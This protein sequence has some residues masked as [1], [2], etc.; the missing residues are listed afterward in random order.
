MADST[1][2]DSIVVD[3]NAVEDKR[4]LSQPLPVLTRKSN[5]ANCCGAAPML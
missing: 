2:V 3:R 5:K 4:T 1:I